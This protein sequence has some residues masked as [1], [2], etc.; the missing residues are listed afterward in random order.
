[1]LKKKK[2]VKSQAL[3]FFIFCLEKGSEKLVWKMTLHFYKL[4]LKEQSDLPRWIDECT[5]MQLHWSQRVSAGI[6]GRLQEISCWPAGR[7]GV[8]INDEAYFL[9]LKFKIYNLKAKI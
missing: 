6:Q 9:E 1:M 8:Y 5:M 4:I 7:A 3:L 2:K